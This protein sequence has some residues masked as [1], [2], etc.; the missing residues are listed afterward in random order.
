MSDK[1]PLMLVEDS[2]GS[3]VIGLV[4]DDVIFACLTGDVSC[5][6]AA[7]LDRALQFTLTKGARFSLFVDAHAPTVADREARSAV[8]EA[9]IRSRAKL[10]GVTALLD[11][12]H[13]AVVSSMLK[14]FGMPGSVLTDPARF[15]QAVTQAVPDAYQRVHYSNC[16][17]IGHN[18]M[19]PTRREC[20]AALSSRRGAG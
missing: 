8:W 7:Q 6:L 10:N 20:I 19:Q 5:E 9:L 2:S 1:T 17:A 12:R 4:A 18:L 16:L 3:G 13:A 14:A 15:D 11:S